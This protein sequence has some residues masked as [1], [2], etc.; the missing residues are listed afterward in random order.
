AIY[1]GTGL[2]GAYQSLGIGVVADGAL[3][4]GG[5]IETV[6]TWGIRGGYTHNW[7]PYWAS[8][9]YGGYAQLQYGS[10]TKNTLCGVARNGVGGTLGISTAAGGPG[11][12]GT[13]ALSGTCNPDFNLGVVGGNIV[14]TPVKGFTF[15]FDVNATFL[16][17][18]YNGTFS[19][20]N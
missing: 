16:D 3:S 2:P 9:L 19:G 8:G 13:G 6:K 11:F 10:N 17:Q 1:G 7:D 5:S 12:I 4:P 15:T 14:W 18:K 20:A